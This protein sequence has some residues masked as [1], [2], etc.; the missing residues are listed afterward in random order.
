MLQIIENA[1]GSYGCFQRL[2]LFLFLSTERTWNVT[3]SNQAIKT[4]T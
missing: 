3:F 4:K 2:C 1:V